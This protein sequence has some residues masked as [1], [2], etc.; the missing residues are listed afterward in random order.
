MRGVFYFYKMHGFIKQVINKIIHSSG[1]DI[2]KVIIILP[3]KRSRIF[4]KQEIS[5]IAKKTIFSPIIYDIENF[6][7]IVSGVDRIS[8]T[9][10]LFEFYN[11]Y[12]NQTKKK[13][14]Q[15]FEEFISWSKTLLKDFSEVDR[16][17]CDTDL[18]FDYLKAFKDLT[19]W[20]NY[21]KETN[22]IKN[23]K[24]FWG[25]IRL[26]HNKLKTRL[27]N[28][29][30][31]Y[32]GLIY[33]EA[34]EQILSYTEN[35]K[36]IKH[37][38]IGF[39]ALS[40]SESEVIQE[41]VNSHG[42]IYWDID[43]SLLNSDYNNSSLFIESY[44]KEWPYYKKNNIEIVSNEYNKEKNI[45]AI[46][47]PKN[48]GQVK[49][50]G[51]LLQSM[52]TDE[53]NETAVVL[54]DE[55]LL[56]PLLN[57]IPRNVKN[58]NV[59]MGYPLKNSNIYS[60]FYLLLS[61]HTKSQNKFYYKSVISLVSHELISPVLNKG[62]DLRKKIR[63]ENLIYMSKKDL[64]DLDNENQKIYRLLFSKWNNANNCIS[65]CIELIDFIKKYYSKNPE[66]DFINLELLLH[67]NKIFLQIKISCEKLDYL[68]NINSLKVLFKELCEMSASP[69]SGEPIKGL[70]I[71]GMLE[72]RLLNYKNII[73]TS[74]NEGILPVGNSNS[75]Y[76]PF[77]IKK[78]NQLQ[79]FKEKD[80]VFAYHFYRLIKRAQKIW[81]IYNTEPDAMN[82]GEESRF[83]RQI[84]VEGIHSVNK[85]LL[86]SKTP[87]NQN[88]EPFYKKTKL[89]E[90]K[91]NTI[92]KNGVSASM[93][94]QY[95]MDQI[96]F[97]ETYVLGLRE[98]NIEETIA[99]STIGNIVHDS[100]ELI[101]KDYVGK[102]LIIED[103]EKMKRKI[104]TTVQNI[105]GNYVR[106]ENIY[107][108]K[109]I[110]IVE[111]VKE[112]VKK[113]IDLDQKTIEK[114]NIL[115]IIA[116]EREFENEIKHGGEKFKIRGKIDRIDELNGEI[117][118][119]D[120]KSGKKLNKR[121]LTIKDSEELTKEKGIYN[122]QLLIYVLGI[123]EEFKEKTI[124][125]GI[126]N[127]K[128]ISEG[129]MEG[130]FNG[131]TDLSNKDME[132]YKKRIIMIITDILNKNK[133]FE[134]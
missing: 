90:E 59:T 10:L 116:V 3:N 72:T 83:I 109:N 27:L 113:V 54:G 130:V 81:L 8:D 91:L 17:L 127:L 11:I 40:K 100:L 7:S 1:T 123:K 75:S 60:F 94:C 118:V 41:I 32:Q 31:G 104:N 106:E 66:N 24:E 12:L 29:G 133:L 112:Y 126:I 30:K 5:K 125:S 64:I 73:V 18:L 120:Y 16:E 19:H 50:V 57:S 68:K 92:I 67:I 76:I 46:G 35:K 121:N 88:M 78:A 45:Q 69:F 93:L 42:E 34:C 134:N 119:I 114:G 99:S 52:S 33:R 105:I 103:L 131:K 65:S 128:N 85:N 82:N 62:I 124:K 51:E 117:R 9:E 28:I 96:K 115:K 89:V 108:G 13:E 2:S 97:F 77:E 23:Y 26:Y 55:K 49:Y 37:I 74:V 58:I 43:K 36:S 44:L 56:I 63:D 98:E 21:E 61:I 20:S 101:Y 132:N 110:I 38:F 39:N 25:K 80:A 129:V 48:I 70:Q 6:M 4:L 53:I 14:Q 102:K 79:T 15:T 22:L 107:K 86:I 84:E 111:T 71:M 47:T 87:V 95:A 122:L